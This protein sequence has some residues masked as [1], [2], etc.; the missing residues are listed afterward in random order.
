MKLH[1][2]LFKIDTDKN[3]FYVYWETFDQNVK[4]FIF[5]F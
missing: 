3:I 1:F 5:M 2:V 4:V